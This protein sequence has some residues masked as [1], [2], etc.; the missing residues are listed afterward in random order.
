MMI[1]EPNHCVS[2]ISLEGVGGLD[3]NFISFSVEVGVRGLVL[4]ASGQL[5]TLKSATWSLGTFLTMSSEIIQPNTQWL[6]QK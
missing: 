2:C 3:Q 6:I 4:S 5:R 1:L